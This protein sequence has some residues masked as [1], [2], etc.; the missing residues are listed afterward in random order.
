M[1]GVRAHIADVGA[2]DPLTGRCRHAE[3]IDLEGFL[4]AVFEP[5]G[6]PPDAADVAAVEIGGQKN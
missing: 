4:D 6:N 2:V 1:T 5:P 3:V